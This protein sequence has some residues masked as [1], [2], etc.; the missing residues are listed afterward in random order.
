MIDKVNELSLFK[1]QCW[2]NS[3]FIL[4][5]K[6]SFEIYCL[7]ALNPQLKSFLIFD[8]HK[9]LFDFANLPIAHI[10]EAAPVISKSV[11]GPTALVNSPFS[12]LIAEVVLHPHPLHSPEMRKE[13]IDLSTPLVV[14]HEE[15]VFSPETFAAFGYFL[16]AL[17]DLQLFFNTLPHAP[18]DTVAIVAHGPPSDR[19]RDVL[20]AA[21]VV[22]FFCKGIEEVGEL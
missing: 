12:D 22:G 1:K 9:P 11:A 21:F 15:P 16:S 7:L 4:A 3:S 2:T 5:C 13:P 8:Y 10:Y 14:T 19:L 17:D 18:W 20:G 6:P